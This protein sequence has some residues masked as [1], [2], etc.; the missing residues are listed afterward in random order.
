LKEQLRQLPA[1]ADWKKR[2][3]SGCWHGYGKPR[4]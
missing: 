2:A 4:S 3:W 1:A